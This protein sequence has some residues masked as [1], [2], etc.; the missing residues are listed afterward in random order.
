MS[1]VSSAKAGSERM[2]LEDTM[3]AIS[4]GGVSMGRS[5]G[6]AVGE[7]G[8]DLTDGVGV[9]TNSVDGGTRKVLSGSEGKEANRVA[10]ETA[11]SSACDAEEP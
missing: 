3:D 5:C 6:S 7:E 4:A 11:R 1:S 10:G 2:T 8:S 9:A